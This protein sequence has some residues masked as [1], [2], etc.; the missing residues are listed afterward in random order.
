MK[1][2]ILDYVYDQLCD[3]KKVFQMKIDS[4][5]SKVIQLIRGLQILQEN[6]LKKQEQIVSIPALNTLKKQ[7][8]VSTNVLSPEASAQQQASC[9]TE[10]PQ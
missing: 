9:T 4:E 5:F 7:S 1:E 3:I 6:I 8:L 2:E 10:T